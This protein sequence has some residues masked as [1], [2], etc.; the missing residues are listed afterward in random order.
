MTTEDAGNYPL[1]NTSDELQLSH[2]H[3]QIAAELAAGLSD[4]KA[5]KERYSISDAQWRKLAKNPTFRSMISDA[6]QTWRGDLNAGQRITK[7]AE[8]LLE[9][10]LPVL[11]EIAHN[12]TIIPSVRIDAIKQ[13]ESITGRKAKEAAVAANGG[14]LVLNI[15]IG[16]GKEKLVVEGVAEAEIIDGQS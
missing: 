7:K 2:F 12:K 11:D 13:M 6:I 1:A 14:G 10:S 9:D 16:Q 4:A 8:I 5:I 3:A 15:N